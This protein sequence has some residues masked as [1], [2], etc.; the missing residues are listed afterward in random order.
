VEIAVFQETMEP[1]V[2][3]TRHRS[4]HC[5]LRVSLPLMQP[6]LVENMRLG[7]VLP[8]QL[9]LRIGYA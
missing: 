7:K 2:W 8:D 1:G 9:S 5:H 6:N 3:L 4:A